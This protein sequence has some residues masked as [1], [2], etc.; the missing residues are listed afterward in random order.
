VVEFFNLKGK[1][2]FINFIK[3]ILF[4][5]IYYII[6]FINVNF[7]NTSYFIGLNAAAIGNHDFDFGL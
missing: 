4:I 1:Y 6:L 2:K 7:F 3:T 5:I